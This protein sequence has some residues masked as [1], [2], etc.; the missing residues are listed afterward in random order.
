M[1]VGLDDGVVDAIRESSQT[2]FDEGVLSVAEAIEFPTTGG[3]TAHA[4]Y[5]A[6]RNAAVDAGPRRGLSAVASA[7]VEDPACDAPP[8]LAIGHGGPTASAS[9]ALDP[10]IQF[11]TSRGFA[12]VDVNYGGSAGYGRE[13]RERLRGEWGH[14]DVDDMVHAAQHL[15]ADRS[16]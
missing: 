8:L 15:A 9:R 12:V 16:C 13:Y 2:R 10:R 1:R 11:W 7:E 4:F 14:V 6:P 3:R 5:Y